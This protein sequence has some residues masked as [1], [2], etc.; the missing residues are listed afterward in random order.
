MSHERNDSLNK[1][2]CAPYTEMKKYLLF[3]HIIIYRH[4]FCALIGWDECF[5]LFDTYTCQA[6]LKALDKEPPDKSYTKVNVSIC[7]HPIGKLRNETNNDPFVATPQPIISYEINHRLSTRWTTRNRIGYPC[8]SQA[9]SITRNN[10]FNI[11]SLIVNFI[12]DTGTIQHICNNKNVFIVNITKCTGV[13]ISGI[14][15]S[16]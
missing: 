13:T 5:S 15:R 8:F 9:F 14:G 1:F 2:Y 7:E 10:S 16:I 3:I 4:E 12:M 6:F 11:F